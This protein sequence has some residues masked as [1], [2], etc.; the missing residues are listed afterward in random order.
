MP[1]HTNEDDIASL[2]RW[3]SDSEIPE[4]TLSRLIADPRLP[5]AIRTLAVNALE[6][7]ASNKALDGI[8]KDAGRYFTAM[9]VVYLHASGQ[10]TLPNLKAYCATTKLLSPG[11]ARALLSYLRYLKF[12]EPVPAE[13]RKGPD[14]DNAVLALLTKDLAERDKDL[15]RM[16]QQFDQIKA[17]LRERAGQ[18]P[19]ERFIVKPEAEW[20]V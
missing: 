1:T 12:I 11:R 2:R 7:S 16:R 10:L 8:C 14:K 3:I 6:A 17:E 18:L 20:N 5:A 9:L 13:L 4:A 15:E 19:D